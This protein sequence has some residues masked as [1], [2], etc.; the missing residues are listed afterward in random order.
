MSEGKRTHRKVPT[1]PQFSYCTHGSAEVLLPPAIVRGGVVHAAQALGVVL[2][3]SDFRLVT[4]M[5]S[6]HNEGSSS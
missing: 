2:K 6:M 1:N 5:V 4:F 3:F